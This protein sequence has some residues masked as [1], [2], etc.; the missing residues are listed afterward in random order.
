VSNAMRLLQLPAGIQGLLVEGRLTAGHAR[1]LLGLA[2]RQEQDQLARRIVAEDLTVRQ[3]EQLVRQ[4]STNPGP[5]QPAPRPGT[6]KPAA[7]LEVESLLGERLATRVTVSV[8][9]RKGKLVI[10]FA[11]LEDLQR[12]FEM[13][14]VVEEGEADDAGAFDQVAAAAE[15]RGD[16]ASL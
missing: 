9:E 11:D 10:D 4:G 1:A 7:I 5:A 2:S 6:T 15:A 14:N 12:I 16:V 13:L 8:G 3:V